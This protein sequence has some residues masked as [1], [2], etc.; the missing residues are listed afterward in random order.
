MTDTRWAEADGLRRRPAGSRAVHVVDWRSAEQWDAFVLSAA[1]STH[2]HRWG[3][4]RV[5]EETYG[6]PTYALAAVRSG[7]L[8]GVL[9]MVLV[10]SHLFGRRL[11]SMPYLDSGGVCAN[12]DTEAEAVLVAAALRTAERL[13]VPLELRQ[14]ECRPYDLPA[15]TSKVTMQLDLSGGEA[16]VWRR[17][18]SNRRGQVRKAQRNE[19]TVEVCGR[20]GVRPLFSVLAANMRDLGSPVHRSA[21]FDNALVQFDEDAAVL[22]V[23]SS[24]RVIGA[25]LVIVHGE[26]AVLPFSSALRPAFSLGPNQLLYWEALRFALSRGCRIFDFGR[27]TPGSGTHEAKREWGAAPVQLYWYQSQQHTETAS[28]AWAPQVWRRLPVPVATWA[29]YLIRGG[30]AQ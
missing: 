21:F 2:A 29:S 16:A 8:C 11:V 14:L 26:C 19:L 7:A 10:K 23:R 4:L 27:S 13:K 9:P 6:H 3:W 22:V 5:V 30:L 28:L 18:S 15:S 25:G 1:D 12:G 24:G 17:I 20:D